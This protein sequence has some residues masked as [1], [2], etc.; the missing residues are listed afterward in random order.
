MMKNR[1]RSDFSRGP[2]LAWV[3]A[4][5][6]G[7]GKIAPVPVFAAF[8]DLGSGARAAGMGGVFA[9]VADDLH[10]YYYNPAG[11]ARL[12]RPQFGVS[13]SRLHLG[14][15]DGSRL[16]ASQIAFA[17][18]FAWG[19]PAVAFNEFSLTGLYGERSLYLSHGAV[20]W[21]GEGEALLGGLSLKHLTLSFDRPSEAA[22]A[23]DLDKA[24]GEADPV[25]SASPSRS[26]LDFDAGILY[27]FGGRYSLGLA[28]EH[29]AEPDLAFSGSDQ[30]RLGR[31]Y[32]LGLGYRVL[33]MNLASELRLGR[34][35]GGGTDTEFG[36]AFER[37]FPTRRHGQWGLRGAFALGSRDR[38]ELS[39][40]A[41]YRIN[42]VQFD[43]GF[44]MPFGT[45][46]RTA[47][48]HRLGLTFHFGA[49]T[50]EESRAKALAESLDRLKPLS[51]DY[52]Y[53]FA[54]LPAPMAG[55]LDEAGYEAVRSSVAAGLYAEAYRALE[56]QIA[57]RPSGVALVALAGRLEEVSRHFAELAE[58]RE[59]WAGVLRQAIEDFLYGRDEQAA[60]RASY[61][62]SL[63]GPDAALEA[64]LKRL[65]AVTGRKAVR[66]PAGSDL[67]RYLLEEVARLFK[68]GKLREAEGAAR[69]ALTLEPRHPRALAQLGSVLYLEHRPV[70]ALAAW[71]AAL[72]AETDL[73]ERENLVFRMV[74]VEKRLAEDARRKEQALRD[75]PD[76]Q[77]LERLYQRGVETYLGGNWE[78]A[79]RFF[80]KML[81]LDPENEKASRALER[82][83]RDAAGK[84]LE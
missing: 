36:L 74:Q 56:R 11:L 35:P 32:R 67:V 47:G 81:E 78:K 60:L 65:E 6:V 44:A 51:P 69:R 37:Y 9:A 33:W 70:Q 57:V 64:F 34:G 58:P 15:S 4:L 30:A 24:T 75:R 19:T 73:A 43:Y 59:K 5:L 72:K 63:K 7:W 54:D 68:A 55:A 42:K 84:A 13:H 31:R 82:I 26:A 8:E 53:E 79:A 3:L 22:N 48:A 45:V 62:L 71:K 10:A 17:R 25:L 29:L 21:E 49:P 61:A 23:M 50:P 27:N 1:D 28:A 16:G 40:G 18:P 46:S 12:E 20:L 52:A 14:L 76:P 41:G 38:R 39:A 80:E 83:A 2:V 77:A 66:A